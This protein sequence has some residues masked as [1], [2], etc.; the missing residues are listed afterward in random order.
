MGGRWWVVAVVCVR[1]SVWVWVGVGGLVVAR[2]CVSVLVG[3]RRARA[4]GG[5]VCGAVG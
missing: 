5:L 3:G 4:G 1:V 2:A